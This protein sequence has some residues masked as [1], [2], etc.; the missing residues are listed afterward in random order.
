MAVRVL[1]AVRDLIPIDG[2]IGL[3][4][5]LRLGLH[6]EGDAEIA[7]IADGIALLGENLSQCLAGILV[8]MGDIVVQV[9]LDGLEHGGPVR[10]FRRAVIADDV[11]RLGRLPRRDQ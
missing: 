3:Q 2:L 8:V 5:V 7:D 11:G 1:Q 4:C 10:P 9:G 6:A